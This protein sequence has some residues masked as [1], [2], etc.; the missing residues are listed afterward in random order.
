MP[1]VLVGLV[2]LGVIVLVLVELALLF[3]AGYT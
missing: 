2:V 1:R 3:Q